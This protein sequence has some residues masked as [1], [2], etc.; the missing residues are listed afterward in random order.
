MSPLARLIDNP[1]KVAVGVLLIALFGS[2]ALMRMPLQLTP[3]VQRPTI[4]I[5]C[6]SSI[7]KPPGSPGAIASSWPA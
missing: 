3:E 2:L 7:S 6:C 4:T 1:V 5:E